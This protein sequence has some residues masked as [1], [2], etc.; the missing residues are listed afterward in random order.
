MDSSEESDE[1]DQD[2]QAAAPQ[3]KH[4]AAPACVV[5]PS[6]LAM[7]PPA[8]SFTETQTQVTPALHGLSLQSQPQEAQARDDIEI[9]P[10]FYQDAAYVSSEP[11]DAVAPPSCIS[12]TDEEDLSFSS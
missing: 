4:G 3:R 1:A 9:D 7:T 2:G 11:E 5:D 12:E 10:Y 8:Q 6:L